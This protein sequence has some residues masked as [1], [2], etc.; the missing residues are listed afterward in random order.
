MHLAKDPFFT[1][2]NLLSELVRFSRLRPDRRGFFE[3]PEVRGQRSKP[4]SRVCKLTFCCR[5]SREPQPC[6]FWYVYAAAV[7]PVFLG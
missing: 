7:I 1:G 6:G 2:S 5:H 4:Y 3:R